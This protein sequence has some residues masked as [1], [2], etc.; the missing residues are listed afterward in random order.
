LAHQE[1]SDG[2][3]QTQEHR[4]WGMGHN[5]CCAIK[6]AGAWAL[7]KDI[8]F[9]QLLLYK[10]HFFVCFLLQVRTLEASEQP[11][12]NEHTS[13]HEFFSLLFS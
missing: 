7:Q 10:E 12:N 9:W 5:V 3:F 6:S 2:N 13:G 8:Q 4:A 11:F 1:T